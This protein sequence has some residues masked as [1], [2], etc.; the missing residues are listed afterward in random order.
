MINDQLVQYRKEH[1]E[2]LLDNFKKWLDKKALV[3]TPQSLLGK[4]VSYT[5]KQWT[6]LKAY[7]D[8]G[9]ATPDNNLAENAI[10]PFVV[11]RKNWLFAGT[12]DGAKASATVYSLI[13]TAKASKLD[14]YAYL[15]FLF[16]ALPLAKCEVD[17]RKLLPTVVTSE[18]MPPLPGYSVV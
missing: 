18:I 7:I 4:A 9:E 11:G 8:V 10:R 15:R 12:P 1:A 3:T 17:Y 5:L 16:E 2:P 13:E 14:V 6:R